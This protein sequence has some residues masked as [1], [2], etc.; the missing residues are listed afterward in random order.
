[1]PTV[2]NVW[3]RVDGS[4]PGDDLRQAAGRLKEAGGEAVVDFSAVK[5]IDAGALSALEKLAREAESSGVKLALYGVNVSVYKALKV[6]KLVPR[7][8][9]MH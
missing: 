3:L 4:D 8:A 2:S 6:M 5:R 1:M 9:V 7:V